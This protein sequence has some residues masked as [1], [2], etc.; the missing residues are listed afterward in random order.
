VVELNQDLIVRVGQR[1]KLL[2]TG[3]QTAGAAGVGLATAVLEVLLALVEV[4]TVVVGAAELVVLTALEEV[5]V[6][7]AEEEVELTVVETTTLEVVGTTMLEVVGAATELVLAA[8]LELAA[9]VGRT[10]LEPP[11]AAL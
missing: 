9:G 5:E 3:A 2:D 10:T 8:T 11:F 6:A 1:D 7:T 4:A